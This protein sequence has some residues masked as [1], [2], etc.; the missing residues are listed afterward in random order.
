MSVL[1]FDLVNEAATQTL[2]GEIARVLSSMP[3]ASRFHAD[4]QGDLGAGKTTLVRAILRGLGFAG[5]VKSPTYPLLELYQIGGYQFCHFDLYRLETPDAFS[6]AGFDEYFSTPGF[7][8]VEWPERAAD[9]LPPPDWVVSLSDAAQ[10]GRSLQITAR[11]HLGARCL[12]R[13][14]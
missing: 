11:T 8:F 2:G 3:E 5:R 1:R 14:A 6:E 13:L 4:L 9:R 7:C 10:G 12:E